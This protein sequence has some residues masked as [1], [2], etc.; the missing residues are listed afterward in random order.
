MLAF[1]LQAVPEGGAVTIPQEITVSTGEVLVKFVLMAVA[2]GAAGLLPVL[3]RPSTSMR[4][5]QFRTG[6]IYALM[7]A[8]VVGTGLA[9]VVTGIS[10]TRVKYGSVEEFVPLPRAIFG[11]VFALESLGGVLGLLAGASPGD[12]R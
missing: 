10:L 12:A 3:L 1:L 11:F 5:Q 9:T 8:V 6:A 7:P 4:L 2:A